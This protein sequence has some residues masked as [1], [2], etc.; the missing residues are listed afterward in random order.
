[1]NEVSIIQNVYQSPE[2]KTKGRVS[3]RNKHLDNEWEALGLS[4]GL[5]TP[6]QHY[7]DLVISSIWA[8]VS[9]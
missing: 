9:L 2:G 7:L 4:S 1:M 5:A 6:L 3:C 8:S